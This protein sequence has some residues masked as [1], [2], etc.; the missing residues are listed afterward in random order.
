MKAQD[1]FASRRQALRFALAGCGALLA[2]A[3]PA[4]E[5]VKLRVNVQVIVDCVPLM[6]AIGQGYFADEGLTVDTSVSSGGAVGIPG[7]VG[8]A[9]D[10]VHSNTVSGLLAFNQGLDVALIAPGAKMLPQAPTTEMV[11]R[12]GEVFKTAAELEGK[13]IGVNNRNSIVWLY[14]RAWVKARGGDP[15]KVAFREVPFPQMEDAVRRRNVDMAFMVEPFKS[16]ALR[17]ADLAVA[18]SPFN[19]VQPGADAGGYLTS[20]K[21][22]SQNPDTVRKFAKALRRGVDWYDAHL[23]SKEALQAVADFTRLP[24]PVLEQITLPPMPTQVEVAQI[25]KTAELM[26]DNGMLDKLPDVDRY[27]DRE[28]LA[29]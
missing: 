24:L 23:Q 16:A 22:A 12:K 25:R 21:F 28:V 7:L 10:I 3:T 18:G 9:F 4:A 13:S 17:G 6:V 14:A 8:G 29:D 1:D 2:G 15:A 26:R 11:G 20:R 19:E 5:P 27:V